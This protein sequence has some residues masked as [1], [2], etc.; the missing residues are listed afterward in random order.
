MENKQLPLEFEEVT[1]VKDSRFSLYKIWLLNIGK[2]VHGS[3]FS[4]NAVLEALPTLKNIPIVVAI[5]ED[6]F[7]ESDFKDHNVKI[8]VENNGRIVRKKDTQA[9]GVIP[10]SCN[11]KFEERF[12]SV[13]GKMEEYLTVEAIVWNRFDEAVNILNETGIKKQ[14]MELSNEYEGYEN[15]EG[16]FV[17]TKFSFDG[18]CI[19]GDN[20]TSAIP[21]STIEKLPVLDYSY[22]TFEE[23]IEKEMLDFQ[24]YYEKHLGKELEEVEEKLQKDNEVEAEKEEVKDE[25]EAVATE[26]EGAE[27]EPE[28]AGEQSDDSND[29]VE[30]DSTSEQEGEEDDSEKPEDD[31][32]EGEEKEAESEDVEEKEAEKETEPEA[33]EVEE[34]NVEP[35][36]DVEEATDFAQEKLEFEAKIAELEAE[37]AELKQF[38]EEKLKE[39]HMQK[40]EELFTEFSELKQEDLDS[41]RSEAI[42]F[43]IEDMEEKLFALVG[44]QE[45]EKKKN[46][47]KRATLDFSALKEKHD[48]ENSELSSY[49]KKH[50]I[51]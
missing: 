38:K 6:I 13:S 34:S 20:I 10:E 16:N 32:S 46:E 1:K 14:S 36:A 26:G 31:K 44:K 24:A 42:N 21:N 23:E 39:E 40:V 9:I 11:P 22:S 49:F 4:K 45:M 3:I 29:E 30:S 50:G 25:V 5:E 35:E 19:L 15:E 7:G 43:S 37:N 48:V 47:K 18:S 51:S 17:F 33:E 8:T 41:L 12:N 27:V 28:G 2:N